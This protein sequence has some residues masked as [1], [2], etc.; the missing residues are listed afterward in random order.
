M[1]HSPAGVRRSS[2]FSTDASGTR[3]SVHGRPTAAPQPLKCRVRARAARDP[4]TSASTP[5]LPSRPPPA[6]PLRLAVPS[7]AENQNPPGAPQSPPLGRRS[8]LK[9]GIGARTT[10]QLSLVDRTLLRRTE[11][12]NADSLLTS[13]LP[14][15]HVGLRS[16]PPWNHRQLLEAD[17]PQCYPL[18]CFCLENYSVCGMSPKESCVLILSFP[19]VWLCQV[20]SEGGETLT[21]PE[22]PSRAGWRPARGGSGRTGRGWRDEGP[23]W[24]GAQGEGCGTFGWERKEQTRGH[25]GR[26]SPFLALQYRC[27]QTTRQTW[28]PHYVVAFPGAWAG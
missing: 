10:A 3:A 16:L 25:C 23:H 21:N 7:P 27:A 4:P 28:C 18:C 19:S 1:G 14:F 9:F 2:F 26:P 17:R 11:L 5:H 8:A 22:R 24:F 15:L 20:K 6:G 13:R 12:C